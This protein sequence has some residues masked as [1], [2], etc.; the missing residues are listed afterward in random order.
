MAGG[1]EIGWAINNIYRFPELYYF[2]PK[3][4]TPVDMWY[5]L[6][7]YGMRKRVSILK[8]IIEKYSGEDI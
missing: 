2:K 5:P 3:N 1:F 7:E 8:H 4:R 6:D